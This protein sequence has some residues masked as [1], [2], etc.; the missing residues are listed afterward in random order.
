[1]LKTINLPNGIEL[2]FDPDRHKYFRNGKEVMGVTKIAEMTGDHGWRI[3]WTAKMAGAQAESIL[4]DVATSKIQID[5]VN[6]QSYVQQIKKAHRSTSSQAIAFGHAGHGILETYV[7][8]KMGRGPEPTQPKN[9]GLK[10][11]IAPY[12]S[13]SDDVNPDYIS[14]EEVV[15]YEGTLHG[16]YFEYAGTLDVRFNLGTEHCI[17][18]FKTAKENKRDYVWQMALYAAAVEQSFGKP[19]DK[20]F[21]FKLPKDG[22]EYKLRNIEL[23]DRYRNFA[24]VLAAMKSMAFE[25]DRAIK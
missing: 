1:M 10:A 7:L 15:Y 20:L 6:Y 22:H 17:G 25:I 23:D 12:I 11:A 19:V 13:W 5:E 14:S 24:P 21:L 4:L 16:Q 8:W 18:D 9:D 2:K 3:P